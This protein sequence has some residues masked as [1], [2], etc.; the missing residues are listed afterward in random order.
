MY[1]FQISAHTQVGESIGLVGSIPELGE[2]DITRCVHLQTRADRYPLWSVDI[3]I[4]HQTVLALADYSAFEYKYV[5][6]KADGTAEWE[7]WG[8]NRWLPLD[9]NPQSQTLVIEDGAFGFVQPYPFGHYDNVDRTPPE[10]GPQSLKAVILGS[11]V[12]RGHKAWMMEGWAA[13]LEQALH[14]QY[15]HQ[16]VN[17]SEVGANVSRTL[18]R[19]PEVVEPE[20]PDI[21]V[22]ALSLGNE[23]LAY[24]APEEQLAVQR[25]FESGL[26]RLIKMTWDIGA[27]PILGGVYPHGEYT[28]EQYAV[29]QETHQRML[30]W[31][32]PVLDWLAAV[33]D[34]NGRW[35]PDTSYDPA[36]PN[37]LGQRLMFEAIAL[38]F[39][40]QKQDA[41]LQERRS[42]RPERIIYQDEKG[43]QVTAD[44]LEKQVRISNPS[45]Q[46]Y[47]IHRLWP[48]LQSALHEK[49]QLV[50]GLYWLESGQP[51]VPSVFTVGPH[52][53]IETTVEV[54]PGAE[55]SYRPAF[56]FWM[57]D[58]ARLLF[59]DG[60]LGI[61]QED[62][63]HLRVFNE[64][65]HA[66]N[67]HPMWKE[68]RRALKAMPSGVYAD[69]LNPDVPFRT[70]M[71]GDEGLESRV[72]AP[73]HSVLRLHYQCPLSEINRIAIVPLGDRCAARMMLYKMEYDGPAFPFDLTR[74]TQISDIAD[75]IENRFE[76]MW[77]PEFL[78]YSLDAGRIYHGKWSGLSFAHEV[79]ETDDPLWDMTPV[80]ERMRMRYS[81]RAQRFWYTLQHSDKLLFVRTGWAD[82]N[83]VVDLVSKLEI[84]CQ[85][86]P[87]H[88][89]LISPQP[90]EE[91]A[92]VANM[93]HYNLEFNPD[94]MYEDLG[95][96][97]YCTDVFRGIL[98]SLGVSSK[99]LFWCPPNIKSV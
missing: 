60:Q 21:V 70:L 18:A 20:H 42:Q 12:A 40:Q 34:G 80:F 56:N 23:G 46:T 38:P 57:P 31:G 76:D 84:H 82:R 4:S 95:H 44:V 94:R 47:T 97:L 43:F 22:I 71:V 39:F 48:A 45:A 87:F 86:K 14:Q 77:N 55:L 73:P 79:E 51:D 19:F 10:R 68:V 32:I 72:K 2:W 64:S 93:S 54:P 36:H 1:H 96:W 9:T 33:D 66:F 7:A 74:T 53:T 3:E 58:P 52:G 81:A 78:H 24:C 26:Q 37:T 98:E 35:K 62:E 83:G 17:C 88:L 41:W 67:I 63:Q 99:N 75:I 8:H 85:G 92:D 69:P 30:S 5:R 25:R 28:P 65:D 50:P 29:L 11:S 6:F 89:L 59:Y 91:F 27:R 13:Q 16:V 15:G 61:I 49:A 90:S